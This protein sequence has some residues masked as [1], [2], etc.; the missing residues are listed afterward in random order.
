M[1]TALLLFPLLFSLL[2]QA[3]TPFAPLGA[4]WTYT[5]GS[6]AGPEQ[7]AVVVTAIADTVIQGRTA[8]MLVP[9]TTGC[10]VLAEILTTSNDSLYYWQQE[11]QRFQLLFRW[12]AQPGDTWYT[13][14]S[15]SGVSDTLLWSVTSIGTI[16]ID[17]TVLRQLD[18]TCTGYEWIFSRSS[19]IVTEGLGPLQAPFSWAAGFCDDETLL[20]LRC[21]S[22][23]AIDWMNP[24]LTQCEII[25]DVDELDPTSLLSIS[26]SSV[27][28]GQPFIISLR[29]GTIDVHLR[30]VDASGRIVIDREVNHSET[31]SLPQV[32]VYLAQSIISGSAVTT[33]RLVVY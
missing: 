30:I 3:Q 27:Q 12:D 11:A 2:L 14:V 10:N 26:P 24:Q 29:S 7:Y 4:R 9:N 31:F 5:V 20:G 28:A 23:S 25:M 21:Y 15:V 18:V 17:G 1:G 32:G 6:W 33:Q 13:P 22:D 16:T 8:S 19:G